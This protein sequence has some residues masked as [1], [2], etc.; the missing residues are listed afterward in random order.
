MLKKI[1]S[2]YI[3]LITN[4][5]AYHSLEMNMNNEELESSLNLDLAQF[6][7]RFPV[8]RY[9]IGLNYLYVENIK[10][11]YYTEY[12][13]SLNLM[14]RNRLP[15]IR[16]L[17]FGLGAK[18]LSSK[19]SKVGELKDQTISA[20]PLGIYINFQLPIDSLPISLS[21][22]IYYS[23]KPLTFTDGDTYF[24]QRYELSFEV[25]DKGQVFIGYRDIE[26]ILQKT[27]EHF[28]ITKIAYVG[29]R[30]GF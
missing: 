15:N 6:V 5:S 19:S 24:E 17:T 9:F 23:P 13:A 29:M 3:F 25:V 27:L 20:I 28:S 1:L 2:I 10:N 8:N 7:D 4:L 12:M 14:M 22:N 26:S 21:T 11:E 30:F 16:S 18:F